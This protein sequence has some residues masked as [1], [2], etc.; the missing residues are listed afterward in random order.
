MAETIK[1]TRWHAHWFATTSRGLCLFWPAILVVDSHP[2]I[3]PDTSSPLLEGVAM[4]IPVTCAACGQAFR[5]DAKFA[6]RRGKCPNPDCQQTYTVPDVDEIAADEEDEVPVAKSKRGNSLSWGERAKLNRVVKKKA[7]LWSRI[8]RASFLVGAGLSA[9]ATIGVVLALSLT[10]ST[11]RHTQAAEAKPATPTY[12]QAV[13]PV[14]TKYCGKC[15]SGD[16]AE[17]GISFAKYSDEAAMLKDRKTWERSFEMISNGNMPPSDSP[18]PT[19]A[20]KEQL[21]EYLEAA[22]FRIDC[23]K[24]SDPG[25]VT[26]RRLN[27]S[28]Y[29]NTV[30]DLLGVAVRPADDFPSDDVGYGF[31]N[32]GDVLSLPPLLMEKYLDAAEKIAAEAIVVFD[33][34][35]PAV[36]E[37]SR[38]KLKQSKAAHP[39]GEDG[40]ILVSIGDVTAELDF[41][42]SG[43]YLLRTK[44]AET[45]GGTEHAKMEYRFDGTPLHTFDVSAKDASP[46]T[47][48]FRFKA[49]KGHHKLS[50]AFL[51]DFYDEKAKD[52]S[53]RDRNLIVRDVEIVG[54]FG[55]EPSELP[56]AHRQLLVA[57]PGNEKTVAQAARDNLQPF[58]RRAFRRPVTEAEV[59]RC[60]GFVEQAVKNG[61]P[62]P[63][64]M[65]V[66]V[67]AVL[68]SPHFLYRIETDKKP[69]DPEDK[70]AL[71]DYE[72]ASRLSYFLWSSMP[73]EQLLAQAAQGDLHHDAVLEEQVRRMLKDPKS[74][75]LVDNFAE[76]WLQLRILNEVTPDPEKFPEFGPELR[77]DMKQET[78]RFF[79]AIMREDRSILE[80]LDGE[81]SYVNERLAHH[82]GLPDVKGDFQRVSLSGKNRAGL[83]TQASIL[84]LT[85]NPDRTSPVK[86]GKWVME[87]ILDKPPPPPPPN[88][89]ELAETAKSSPDATLRQQLELHRQNPSCNS[90]HK[91]MDQLGFGIENFDAIGRWRDVDNG[92][93]L[94]AT[95]EL[96]GGS[97]FNGPLELAHVLRGKECEFGECLAEKMLTYALGRGL[98][99]YDRCATDKIVK[100]LKEQKFRFSVLVAEI[101]KSDP[102]RMRRGEESK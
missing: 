31:D 63:F 38:D 90:C 36:H 83:L 67:T 50:I 8:D 48:E 99:F 78:R 17:A 59:G 80:F 11:K 60:V 69:D 45:P 82:Y 47:C 81:Y 30:R 79:E 28:E 12:A 27:R 68:V 94:D 1:V 9:V 55:I 85:S 88:V 100:T 57:T 2:E 6:G 91:V 18:Q 54:P 102:F 15:H 84:T 93:P 76:Q 74:Q 42:H 26:I 35:K 40:T 53:Q 32:I 13:V 23:T 24:V 41:P 70:H 61:E 4:R 37:Y 52:K 7:S 22:L 49:T 75:A 101:A 62:F 65:R 21:I 46:E 29:N 73:D 87:V 16:E 97:R 33:P 72:L 43:E 89:P 34:T 51:N 71:N 3:P 64:G 44:A 39:H 66:A 77:D 19:T 10:T 96:P 56:T 14:I 92:K 25:R 86:R 95:G 5:V 20:E 58:V 98:E